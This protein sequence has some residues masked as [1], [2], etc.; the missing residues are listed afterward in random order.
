MRGSGHPLLFPSPPSGMSRQTMSR[1]E[2]F[3]RVALV[4]PSI[5]RVNLGHFDDAVGF[6][7]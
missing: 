6:A 3:D 7:N 4:A 1:I 2:I 5:R